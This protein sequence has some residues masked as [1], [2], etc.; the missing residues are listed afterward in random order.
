MDIHRIV[1]LSQYQKKCY[2]CES[3]I[4]MSNNTG[5]WLPLNLDGSFH[6]CNN[7]KQGTNGHESKPLTV[8]QRLKRL[9]Q[10]VLDPRR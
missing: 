4:K 1:T 3:E 6:A 9:E 8:E 5:K 2:F 10:I 7:S